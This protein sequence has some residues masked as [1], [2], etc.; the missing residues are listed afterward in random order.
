MKVSE[1]IQELK[2]FPEDSEV[3][4]SYNYGDHW[5]TQVAPE[6]SSVEEQTIKYSGYHSMDAIY[7]G[8]DEEDLAN[9]DT[10]L[11]VVIS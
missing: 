10:R 3:H 7:E 6:V 9:K 5:H 8:D 11:V 2:N 1:L 4:F